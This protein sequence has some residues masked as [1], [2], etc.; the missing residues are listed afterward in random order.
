MRVTKPTR[1]KNQPPKPTQPPSGLEA[2]DNPAGGN[3][4]T[5]PKPATEKEAI[6]TTR[7]FRLAKEL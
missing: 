2:P 6:L 1:R 5:V 3:A 7:N 4:R